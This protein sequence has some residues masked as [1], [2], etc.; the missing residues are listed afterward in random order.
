VGCPVSW[1][2]SGVGAKA[3]QFLF[4]LTG[5]VNKLLQCDDV[6]IVHE[7]LL[8]FETHSFLEVVKL[9]SIIPRDLCCQARELGNVSGEVIPALFEGLEG[10]GGTTYRVEVAKGTVKNRKE[11]W[12]IDQG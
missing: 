4:D 5:V 7:S 10:S 3:S 2:V 1:E 11:S 6:Q 8:E 9:G 12:D